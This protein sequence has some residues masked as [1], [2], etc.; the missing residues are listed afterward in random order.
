MIQEYEWLKKQQ[1]TLRGVFT[2]RESFCAIDPG[3]YGAALLFCTDP[4]CETPNHVVVLP[5]HA[6]DIALAVEATRLK[7]RL[8]VVEAQYHGINART[9]LQLARRTGM[10]M[11]HIAHACPQDVRVVFV[12]PASWQTTLGKQRRGKTKEL[13]MAQ[14]GDAFRFDS[15]YTGASEKLRSGIAD[16]FCM[17]R[18]WRG[19]M[20]WS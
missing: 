13:A 2:N 20:G 19:E 7:V 1:A 18:W 17:A 14:A 8:F 3:Q 5:G 6:N 4:P 9:D 15:R 16:A 12:P 10:L 11:G